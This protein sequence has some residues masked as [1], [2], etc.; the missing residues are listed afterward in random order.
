MKIFNKMLINSKLLSTFSLCL[1]LAG[2]SFYE[3]EKDD[4]T[5]FTF[6]EGNFPKL[7]SVHERPQH[8]SFDELQEIQDALKQSNEASRMDHAPLTKEINKLPSMQK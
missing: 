4:D 7:N 6:I 8:P 2:C 3:D 5:P 1:A